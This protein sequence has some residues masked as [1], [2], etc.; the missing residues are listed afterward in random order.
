[1]PFK[2]NQVLDVHSSLI[3]YKVSVI[4]DHLKKLVS[5]SNIKKIAVQI[6]NQP[7]CCKYMGKSGTLSCTL[8]SG[9]VNPPFYAFTF[10]C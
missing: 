9:L 5:D 1:M 4:W 7:R 10:P 3:L 2:T 8:S 6:S